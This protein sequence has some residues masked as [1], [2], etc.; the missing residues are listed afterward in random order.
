VDLVV[1]ALLELAMLIV[2]VYGVAVGFRLYEGGGRVDPAAWERWYRH[3]GHWFRYV[4]PFALYAALVVFPLAFLE[5]AF[6]PPWAP[7]AA[8]VSV[9]VVALIFGVATWRRSPRVGPPRGWRSWL[10]FLWL[11]PLAWSGIAMGVLEFVGCDP[12]PV[13]EQP[14]W[15]WYLGGLAFARVVRVWLARF[16]FH[17][18]RGLER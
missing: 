15:A 7:G 1:F 10:L 4:G 3:A 9:L 11:E 12:G 16:I 2:G 17:V 8:A 18:Q 5:P 13:S 14:L 6:L